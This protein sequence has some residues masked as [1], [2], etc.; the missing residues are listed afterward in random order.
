MQEH[1]FATLVGVDAGGLPVATQVP[2]FADQQG[3]K[4]VLSGHMMRQTDHHR[5]FVHN[6]QAL[7]IFTGPHA[8]ISAS[9]YPDP[10]QAST[11]NYMAVHVRGPVRFLDDAVLRRMLERTTN[12]FEQRT[13]AFSALPQAYIDRLSPAIIGFELE[14][15][16]INHVFKLSQ[17]KDEQT[18]QEILRRLDAGDAM[19]QAVAREM[20]KGRLKNEE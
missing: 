6:P 18:F 17:N 16:S 1:P 9:W 8:Y 2:L 3:D 20:R 11:W 10:A 15:E 12:H 7:A 4:L 14:A 19:D 13:D 5:A